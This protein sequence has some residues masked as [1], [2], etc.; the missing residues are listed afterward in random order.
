MSD[1]AM[2]V[3]KTGS[4]FLAGSY[5][6]KAA[7]GEEIDNEALG[8]ATTHTEISG[9]TDNKYPNDEACLDEI[10]SLMDKMGDYEKTGFNR[11][12]AQP[13]AKDP[14]EHYGLF[15]MDNARPYDTLEIIHRLSR[16]P[17]RSGCT[18]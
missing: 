7:I 10:R 12:H 8:G 14:K 3:D 11:T 16:T 13:P 1:E 15:T 4:I 9:V 2:I 18:G 17:S 5:L 6:V